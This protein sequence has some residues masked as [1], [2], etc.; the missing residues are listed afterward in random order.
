MMRF[1][2]FIVFMFIAL[3]LSVSLHRLQKHHDHADV[4]VGKKM[5]PVTLARFS[6]ETSVPLTYTSRFT[7]VNLFASWCAPCIE[8]MPLLKIIGMQEGVTVV[9]IAWNDTHTAITSLFKSTPN[10]YEMLY[11]D[12]SG[13]TA[14]ALGMRGIP[15][16]F[17]IDRA[18]VIR[19]HTAGPI[20]PAIWKHGMKPLI[21]LPSLKHVKRYEPVKKAAVHAQ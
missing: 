3:A 9:G 6:D 18:G 2:P 5:P 13:N 20:T 15:E 21:A 12:N 17:L 10:P 11:L 8:E 4:W 1:A 19:F 7:L 14:I 16:S